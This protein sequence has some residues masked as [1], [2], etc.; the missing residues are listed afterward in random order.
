MLESQTDDL[1]S[2][3]S[4]MDYDDFPTEINETD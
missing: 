4:K 3:F 2:L 1:A